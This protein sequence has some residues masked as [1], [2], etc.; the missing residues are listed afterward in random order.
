MLVI[1]EMIIR[2]TM[3]YHYIFIKTEFKNETSV[4]EKVEKLESSYTTVRM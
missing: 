4:A 2:A 3:K 1:S